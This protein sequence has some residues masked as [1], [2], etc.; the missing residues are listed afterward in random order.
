MR[1]TERQ[2]QETDKRQMM[3]EG[4]MYD[5]QSTKDKKISEVRASLIFLWE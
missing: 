4:Q 2:N 1:Q 5:V 3:Y